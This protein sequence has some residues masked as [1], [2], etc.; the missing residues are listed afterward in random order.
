MIIKDIFN[1]IRLIKFRGRTDEGEWVYGCLVREACGDVWIFPH[2]D[3]YCNSGGDWYYRKEPG[4]CIVDPETVGQYTGLK[5]KNGV[6]IYEG[7]IV[8]RQGFHPDYEK[9]YTCVITWD[10]ISCGWR[11]TKPIG[12]HSCS[13]WPLSTP[14][15]MEVVGNIH[16]NPELIKRK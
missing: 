16:D 2:D 3:T 8:L 10:G 11:A 14:N 6:E 15:I 13:D 12:V 5:D 9:Q 7:D 4:F 1:T